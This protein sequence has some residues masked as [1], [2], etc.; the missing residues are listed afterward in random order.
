MRAKGTRL[1]G[2]GAMRR[3]PRGSR[4]GGHVSPFSSSLPELR[5]ERRQT[6]QPVFARHLNTSESTVQKWEAGTKRPSLGGRL[7]SAHAT[8]RQAPCRAL[9]RAAAAR[10]LR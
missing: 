10:V 7:D 9:S 8:P 1:N 6:S 3:L 2:I 4:P 5:A